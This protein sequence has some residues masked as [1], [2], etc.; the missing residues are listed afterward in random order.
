MDK[1]LIFIGMV[2]SQE[3]AARLRHQMQQ[4]LGDKYFILIY[5]RSEPKFE[6]F[7]SK[8]V[9]HISLDDVVEKIKKSIQ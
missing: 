8:D 5:R 2:M 3:S 1:I 4:E 7:Y 6:V 9:N